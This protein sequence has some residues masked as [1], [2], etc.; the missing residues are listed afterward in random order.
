MRLTNQ[1]L[2]ALLIV[3]SL[4]LNG[5][6]KKEHTGSKKSNDQVV[7]KVNGDEITIYQVNFQLG[8][9]GRMGQMNEAQAKLAAKQVLTSLVE[10]QLLKQQALDSKL[11]QD[12]IV[13]QALA[14]S[15]DQLLAQAYLEKLMAKAP[16]PSTSEIDTFYKDHPELFDK[17]RV[18]RL[19]ELVVN[20][21]K[22]KFADTEASLKTIKG[23]NEIATWLKDKNYIFTVNSNVKAAEQLP[24]ELLKKLQGLKDGEVLLVPTDYSFNI[25]QVAASESVPI[26][27][28]KAT[29]II[30]Q[31]FLNQNKTSLAKKEMTALNEKA[32]VE[33][34]GAFSDMKKSELIKPNEI[35]A[36]ADTTVAPE[37]NTESKP[38]EGKSNQATKL[39]ANTTS[40][41]KGLSGL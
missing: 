25:I 5:C 24:L 23:I 29:P 19:Q 16:K 21:S 35:N 3:T 39:N 30:E 20:I 38:V 6:N 40:I 7:A 31:Y 12:P 10:Q 27:R 9:M 32:T 26:T 34:V 37:A 8:R 41:N 33:F 4:V 13:L 11:D 18:F 36:S 17:R 28:S 22:D 15:K 1:Y 2:L 14:S